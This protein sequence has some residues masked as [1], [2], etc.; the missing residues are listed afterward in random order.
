MLEAREPWL[1]SEWHE[2]ADAAS[3][4]GDHHACSALGDVVDFSRGCDRPLLVRKRI[5]PRERM[6]VPSVRLGARELASA[7]LAVGCGRCV[8]CLRRRRRNWRM[9]IAGEIEFARARGGRA[10]FVTLTVPRGSHASWNVSELGRR[11]TLW[12]KRMRERIRGEGSLRYI[13]VAERH[14]DGR[15]HL[16]AIILE[17]GVALRKRI[18][19]DCRRRLFGHSRFKLVVDTE[20]AASYVSKYVTKTRVKGWRMRCSFRFGRDYVLLFPR[21]SSGTE[22]ERREPRGEFPRALPVG[23]EKGITPPPDSESSGGGTAWT[24]REGGGE[25]G[26]R[27]GEPPPERADGDEMEVPF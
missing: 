17:H 16:H 25:P 7:I 10:W 14:K 5:V 27:P 23:K 1:Y 24:Q 11:F 6:G 19:D 2:V 9:R 18:L 4:R 22:V 21:A 13:C 15:F 3:S 26:R 20:K 8:S 12:I